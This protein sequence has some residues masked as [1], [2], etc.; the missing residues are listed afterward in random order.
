[1]QRVLEAQDHFSA[2]AT[3][4]ETFD[5][6]FGS[7]DAEKHLHRSETKSQE[8]HVDMSQDGRQFHISDAALTSNVDTFISNLSANMHDKMFQY[9]TWTG[10]EDLWSFLQL[11]VVR[12][13]IH[14]LFGSALLKQYPRMVRDYLDFNAAAEGFV[15]GMPRM[16][17]SGAAKPRDRLLEGIKKW[18]PRDHNE[19]RRNDTKNNNRESTADSPAWDENTGLATIQEHISHYHEIFKRKDHMLEAIAAEML[20]ITHLYVAPSKLRYSIDVD[21]VG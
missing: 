17:V 16:M 3:Q 8:R 19:S 12:C 21:P 18:V 20:S 7:P 4:V 10:I 9:D 2:R 1:M 14:T 6:L 15:P 11:V 13:T 5:K